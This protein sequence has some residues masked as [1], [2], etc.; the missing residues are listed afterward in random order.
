MTVHCAICN[1]QWELPMKLPI[2]LTRAIAAMRGFVAAGCPSCGAH[3]K[4]V[5][6]GPAPTT[7]LTP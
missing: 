4:N 1:Q 6:C 7:V 2:L 5:L 3:G